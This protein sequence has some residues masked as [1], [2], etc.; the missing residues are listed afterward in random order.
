[1]AEHQ[2]AAARNPLYRGSASAVPECPDIFADLW[3][4]FIELDRG[5]RRG[6]FGPEPLA[7]ADIEAWAALTQRK[8]SPQDIA[9]IVDIDRLGFEI[10]AEMKAQK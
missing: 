3:I 8:L 6:G 7:Y 1:V 9:L 2:A 5:R 4:G 10:R